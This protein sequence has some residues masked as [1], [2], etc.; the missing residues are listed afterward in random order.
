MNWI[1]WFGLGIVL[2]PLPTGKAKACF[3]NTAVHTVGQLSN[4][5]IQFN[6]F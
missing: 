6:R 4:Q 5:L 2:L 3:F 1:S